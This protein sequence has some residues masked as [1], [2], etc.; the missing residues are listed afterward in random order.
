MTRRYLCQVCLSLESG[1][2]KNFEDAM[3][4]LHSYGVDVLPLMLVISLAYY[5]CV[6]T[7]KIIDYRRFPHKGL[8]LA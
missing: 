2:E 5:M 1:S 7:N 3:L 6:S 4:I 8:V